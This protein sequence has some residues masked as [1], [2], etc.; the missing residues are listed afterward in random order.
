MSARNWGAHIV[1]GAVVLGAPSAVMAQ[2]PTY[3][4]PQNALRALQSRMASE[5]PKVVCGM[6]L[7]PVH[8]EI[9][10]KSLKKAPDDKKY[11]MGKVAPE[12]CRADGGM[13]GVPDPGASAPVR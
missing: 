7:A 2:A 4:L 1:I 6:T 12:M 8:P 10:Q 11:T 13:P 5:R 3:K 9:D